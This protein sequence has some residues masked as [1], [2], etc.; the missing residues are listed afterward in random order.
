MPY[1]SKKEREHARW[2]TIVETLT[3]IEAVDKC[4]QETAMRSMRDAIGDGEIEV[5]W[6]QIYPDDLDDFDLWDRPIPTGLTFWQSVPIK[7]EDGG[8][9]LNDDTDY[10]KLAL[11]DTE[12]RQHINALILLPISEQM[13]REKE[14]VNRK[15]EELRARRIAEKKVLFQQI[16]LLRE[17]ILTI[18]PPRPSVD[19]LVTTSA[20]T[21]PRA[22][23]VFGEKNKLQLKRRKAEESEI[24]HT[25]AEVYDEEHK[26]GRPPPNADDAERLIRT[27]LKSEGLIAKRKEIRAVLNQEQFRRQRRRAGNQPKP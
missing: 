23:L 13:K 20:S 3:H 22:D 21:K 26:E 9:V 16:L 14:I 19:Q 5:K 18:W 10:S 25:A 2:M 7:L 8:F 12:T 15:A 1:V 17:C 4:D 11:N 27:K 6:G 24:S